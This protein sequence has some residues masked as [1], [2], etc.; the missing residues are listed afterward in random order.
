MAASDYEQIEIYSKGSEDFFK[1]HKTKITL[2]KSHLRIKTES[3]EFR[4]YHG[5]AHIGEGNFEVV[6]YVSPSN[7]IAFKVSALHSEDING[8]TYLSHVYY[9]GIGTYA[10][11][12]DEYVGITKEDKAFLRGLCIGELERELLEAGLS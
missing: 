9:A 6:A 4:L 5:E 3:Q 12:G 8:A 7:G 1:N 10:Y 11:D 2:Y